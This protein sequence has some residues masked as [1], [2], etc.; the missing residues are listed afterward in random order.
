VLERYWHVALGDVGSTNT[1]VLLRARAGEADGL[2]ITADR[3]LGGRGRRGRQW[4]SEPGN[5][6]ASLL[7]IDPSPMAQ[8]SSLPLAVAVGVHEAIRQSLPSSAIPV[9]IKWPND[10]LVDGGKACGILIESEGL[11]DGRRAV[12]IGC[13]INIAHCPD[14]GLYP[15]TCLAEKGGTS[16]PQDV[17]ARLFIAMA[18]ALERWDCGR[19]L[20]VT[21]SDWLARAGGVGSPVTVN[22]PDREIRG[23]FETID[24]EGRLVLLTADG[25]KQAIA[26][27]DVFFQTP[28]PDLDRKLD[29]KRP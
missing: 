20:A 19:G 15:V 26:A 22:L 23:H 29:D 27:G 25:H 17:F 5:L 18:D 14:A 10:I 16:S 24:S 2:W 1:E 11:A 4:I 12:V 8:L 13:G 28:G 9:R 21:R 6:Y 7:L 3:Q